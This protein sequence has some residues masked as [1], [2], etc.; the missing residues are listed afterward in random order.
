MK[1]DSFKNNAV[2]IYLFMMLISLNITGVWV[3]T[4]GENRTLHFHHIITFFFSLYTIFCYKRFKLNRFN[5]RNSMLLIYYF[6]ALFMSVVAAFKYGIGSTFVNVVYC[7]LLFLIISTWIDT[8]K[9]ASLDKIIQYAGYI[10]AIAIII[11]LILQWKDVLYSLQI[12]ST[13]L[14]IST[15]V[16]GGQNIE[17]TYLATY[18]CFL[19]YKRKYG[20]EM[21]SL[22]ISILYSSRTAILLNVLSIL[23]VM[24]SKMI[25]IDKKSIDR[26]KGIYAVLICFIFIV[27]REIM[28]DM[29]LFDHVIDR[30][31]NIGNDSGSSIRIQ[32][33]LSALKV[34]RRNLFGVGVGNIIILVEETF[35]LNNLHC[36][37]LQ[38]LAETG[39]IGFLLFLLSLYQIL[40]KAVKTRFSNP[41]G[42]MA[43]GYLFCC[44][45]Q[46]RGVEPLYVIII[47]LFLL[48]DD[49]LY[50]PL[51]DKGNGL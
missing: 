23:L 41:L 7:I 38:V 24:V 47:A 35:G 33:W 21:F 40:R 37:Y 34:F 10:F 3:I 42:T 14:L 39:L 36:V 46:F 22:F 17:A 19:L 28:Y 4:V 12:K 16:A 8:L 26:R 27:G 13:H 5:R 25:I 49:S 15:L 20:F 9:W 45:L 43:V 2:S 44:L 11:N 18:A 32:L 29:G 1:L 31:L 50:K 51:I 48:L 30:F 6:F